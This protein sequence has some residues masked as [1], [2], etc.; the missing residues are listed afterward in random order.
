MRFLKLAKGRFYKMKELLRKDWVMII[1]IMIMIFTIAII[2]NLLLSQ[3]DDNQRKNHDT[4]LKIQESR[5]KLL[6]SNPNFDIP[7]GSYY[8][9]YKNQQKADKIEI[10]NYRINQQYT[11]INYT[12]KNNYEYSVMIIPE[13]SN[14]IH[15][16]DDKQPG[17]EL[18]FYDFDEAYK[19]LKPGEEVNLELLITSHIRTKLNRNSFKAYRLIYKN[20]EKRTVI[21]YIKIGEGNE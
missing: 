5:Q 4:E 10:K 13:L 1:G 19:I 16:P 15:P 14:A 21:G 12:L 17:T 8:Q 20:D 9:F 18:L 3:D 2:K 11:R 7:Y 6:K